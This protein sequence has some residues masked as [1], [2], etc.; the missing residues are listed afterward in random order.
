MD[1]TNVKV[2]SLCMP[3][4]AEMISP[5][6]Y[7]PF[8]HW[9]IHIFECSL[10]C[11]SACEREY[12]WSSKV[13]FQIVTILTL[14]CLNFVDIWFV[15]DCVACYWYVQLWYTVYDSRPT[16]NMIK[17]FPW[18]QM[19]WYMPIRAHTQTGNFG[20]QT[21]QRFRAQLQNKSGSGM[22]NLTTRFRFD[23]YLLHHFNLLDTLSYSGCVWNNGHLYDEFF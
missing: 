17:E 6:R 19:T 9:V 12:V 22:W 23:F 4:Y 21:V 15:L 11:V 5:F 1:P 20:I 7:F 8:D 18:L 13:P 16:H 2:W 3:C 14:L 10:F